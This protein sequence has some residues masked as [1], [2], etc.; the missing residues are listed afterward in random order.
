MNTVCRKRG[1][2]PAHSGARQSG[3]DFERG[4]MKQL[5]LS[6]RR[7]FVISPVLS[8][9]AFFG[10]TTCWAGER[11]LPAPSGPQIIERDPNGK[12]PIIGGPAGVS[13]GSGQAVDGTLSGGLPL[14]PSGKFGL[15]FSGVYESDTT[16]NA[17]SPGVLLDP[18]RGN[19]C[20]NSGVY[21]V[22][23]PA[24][25]GYGFISISLIGDITCDKVSSGSSTV[26]GSLS[27][28]GFGASG[29]TGN[30]YQ[31][32][33]SINQPTDLYA[34]LIKVP[35]SG[36]KFPHVEVPL[37]A[38]LPT[39]IVLEHLLDTPIVTGPHKGKKPIALLHDNLT[40]YAQYVAI[41]QEW[42]KGPRPSV[43]VARLHEAAYMQWLAEE[44]V[45]E[46]NNRKKRELERIQW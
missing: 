36:F 20:K 28:P 2:G 41:F 8:V 13:A 42:T 23:F 24:S 4:F 22:E 31:N 32:V 44:L 16:I 14:G 26:G 6:P 29:G 34:T 21:Y 39:K 27:G 35:Q 5:F 30:S 11:T 46:L 25:P 38:E 7:H 45:R 43:D 17:T 10:M 40:L 12:V 18:D 19:V 3:F 33:T 1:V 9:V 15:G 37:N